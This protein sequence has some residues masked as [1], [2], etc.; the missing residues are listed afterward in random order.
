VLTYR[1]EI[2]SVEVGGEV[3]VLHVFSG[4]VGGDEIGDLRPVAEAV[5][6]SSHLYF[7]RPSKSRSSSSA[8]QSLS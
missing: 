1:Q 3:V 7:S 2:G 6:A 8:V 4:L 5:P